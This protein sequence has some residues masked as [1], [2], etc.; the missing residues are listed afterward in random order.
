M[1]SPVSPASS[2]EERTAQDTSSASPSDE[3]GSSSSSEKWLVRFLLLMAFGVAFGIEGMTLFRSYVLD[4]N[5]EQQE[6][7]VET[8]PEL[9]LL[10]VGDEVLPASPPTERIEA[11]TV[12]ARQGETWTFRMTIALRNPT[13][14]PYQLTTFGVLT[15]SGSV[16]EE[17]FRV[18]CPPGDSTQLMAEWQLAPSDFPESLVA[19]GRVQVTP[20]S[21]VVHA[22]RF[23]LPRIPVQMVR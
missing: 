9:P 23:R 1:D 13:D 14:Q 3:N 18:T 21:S 17:A 4:R 2:D 11:L 10:E 19:S 5:S 15:R 12:E 16:H 6:V 22:R 20:D 8:A 7:A